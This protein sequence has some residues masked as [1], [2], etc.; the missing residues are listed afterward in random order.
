MT[1]NIPEDLLF[2]MI[3]E[4]KQIGGCELA[5]DLT[6]QV[7]SKNNLKGIEKL[8]GI[9]DVAVKEYNL[10]KEDASAVLTYKS[11]EYFIEIGASLNEVIDLIIYTYNSL[12][13]SIRLE[14]E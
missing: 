3:K 7:E 9:I 8:L 11:I 1:I 6:E 14:K 12:K 10:S 13:L 2:D 5:G 4:A